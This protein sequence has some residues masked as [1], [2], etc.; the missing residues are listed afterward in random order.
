[1]N[2]LLE[3][4]HVLMVVCPSL[5]RVKT[6]NHSKSPLALLAFGKTTDQNSNQ[7]SCRRTDSE[8]LARSELMAGNFGR[9]VDRLG[10]R[11]VAGYQQLLSFAGVS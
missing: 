2:E 3:L 4:T 5:S 10:C 1:M 9:R 11:S 6:R 7:S 8:V